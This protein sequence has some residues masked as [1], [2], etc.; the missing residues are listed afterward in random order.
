[1]DS[2]GGRRGI[3]FLF[4][5]LFLFL[6]FLFFSFLF[7][8]FLFFS[9]LFFSFLF[10]SFL[11]FFYSF[12]FFSFLFFFFHGERNERGKGKTKTKRNLGVLI[13]KIN[14]SLHRINSTTTPTKSKSMVFSEETKVATN[15]ASKKNKRGKKMRK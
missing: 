7:F 10:F 15:F 8:S 2:K 9:F 1:M 13:G 12:L 3:L 14:V 5:F 11:F 6:S 4:L